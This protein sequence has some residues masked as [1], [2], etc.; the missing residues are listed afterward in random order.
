MCKTASSVYTANRSLSMMAAMPFAV[1]W[2][3]S[4]LFMKP[5]LNIN[6][7]PSTQKGSAAP[8]LENPN[9]NLLLDR[10]RFVSVWRVR[11]MRL[12]SPQWL[13]QFTG[14]IRNN[15]PY[16][17]RWRALGWQS[18]C[19]A[20]SR[21][22]AQPSSDQFEKPISKIRNFSIIAHIDHGKSTRTTLFSQFALTGLVSD[23][24]LE[25]TETISATGDNKQVLDKLKVERERGS[26][27]IAQYLLFI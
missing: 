22:A 19:F 18:R 3:V 4:L 16:C 13:P 21:A 23:R 1:A 26:S 2:A 24:L 17:A 14:L 10:Q 5:S 7:N 27:Q 15:Y 12:F 6:P 11:W 20:T 25:V 9:S 8:C